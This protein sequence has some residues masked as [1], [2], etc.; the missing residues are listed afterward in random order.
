MNIQIHID[1]GVLG[2]VLIV[3][4]LG[5]IVWAFRDAQAREKSG[6]L[7][8]LLVAFPCWPLGLIAWLALRPNK[9]EDEPKTVTR[10][11]VASLPCS[12]GE[13]VCVEERMAGTKATCE[14]CGAEVLIPELSR[15]RK[16]LDGEGFG[17]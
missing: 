11:R 10:V 6:C 5:S 1:G 14:S 17:N 3:L 13:R 12:C 8:A 2:L 4:Y 15:L 9:T 7:S 16:V